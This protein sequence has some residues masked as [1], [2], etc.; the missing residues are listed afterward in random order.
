MEILKNFAVFEGG[1]G[2]GTST[3]LALLEQ[4]LADCGYKIPVFFPTAE[5]TKGP[6]GQLLRSALKNDPFFQ[7]DTLARLFAADRGEHLY[8]ENGIIQRCQRGELVVSDRFT[9]SSLVYQGIE[10]GESL[11]RSLNSPFPVPE[12]L[13]FFDLD[14]QIAQKRLE[15]RPSRE[16]F[17]YFEFQVKVRD[18]Y[19]SLLDEYRKA[20]VRVE[21]IDAAQSVEEVASKVWS[22][23]SKMPIFIQMKSE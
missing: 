15:I 21:V 4:K 18:R 19:L 8:A 2:S 11:P 14:P 1:D 3:Q 9:L 12:L 16:I 10:C 17:E 23:L 6:I 20:G 22:A 5:P 13:L 7:S